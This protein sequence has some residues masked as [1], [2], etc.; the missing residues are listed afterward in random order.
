MHS[1]ELLGCTLADLHGAHQDIDRIQ[2]QVREAV[3][4]P[5]IDA[6]IVNYVHQYTICT[7]HKACPPTQPMLPRYLPEGSWQEITVDYLTHQDKEYLLMCNLFSKY[8]FL[9][10]VTTKPAQ[11]L[12]AC[13]LELISQHGP[14][15]LLSM[16]NGQPF[17][18]EELT[19]FLLCH[20]IE[21]S[22][23]TP[24]FPQVQWLPRVTS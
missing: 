7:K 15:S 10:K 8:P 20:H 18:Y 13:L 12:C 17:S 1:P 4:W 6:Y 2:A 22:T 3:Y 23:P 9:Y 21:H 11:S 14:P 24:H 16:D 5:G 19:Q